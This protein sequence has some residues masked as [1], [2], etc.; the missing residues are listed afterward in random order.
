MK[1]EITLLTHRVP[2]LCLCIHFCPETP[3]FNIV[4]VA[5]PACEPL[6][7]SINQPIIQHRST[8]LIRTSTP[9]TPTIHTLNHL[10]SFPTSSGLIPLTLSS[11][12]FPF[13]FPALILL[14]P[15]S[16]PLQ[17]RLR[18]PTNTRRTKIRLLGL[19]TPD[20]AQLLIPLLLPLSDQRRIRVAVLQQPVVE[21]AADGVLGVE[22]VVDVA[23]ALV[24]DA[25]DGP[26]GFVAFEGCG[27]CG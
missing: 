23:A 10:P 11:F 5:A 21:L 19:N 15:S 7:I 2:A 20:T 12:P 16:S 18:H 17:N 4:Q 14:S 9:P 25:V 13:P 24:G 1:T 8:S 6:K 3:R 27:S 26:E 22:E